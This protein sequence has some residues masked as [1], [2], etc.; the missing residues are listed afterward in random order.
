MSKVE[1]IARE[2]CHFIYIDVCLYEYIADGD[3]PPFIFCLNRSD[4]NET[5]NMFQRH[6]FYKNITTEYQFVLFTLHC[7]YSIVLL[8][9]YTVFIAYA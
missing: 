6:S 9:F 5:P 2:Y 1:N 4:Q 7:K 3:M 8:P